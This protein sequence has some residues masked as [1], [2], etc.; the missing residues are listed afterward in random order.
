LAVRDM[1]LDQQ[2]EAVLNP[3][4]VQDSGDPAG[5]LL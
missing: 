4:A 2:G 1:G 5:D 3:E